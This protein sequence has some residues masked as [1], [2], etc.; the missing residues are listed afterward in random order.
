MKDDIIFSA[1]TGR[2]I[3]EPSGA[4][5]SNVIQFPGQSVTGSKPVASGS[6]A[7]RVTITCLATFISIG[8]AARDE[9]EAVAKPF[10]ENDDI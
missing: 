6:C 8:D 9:I 5:R 10:Q 3:L 7:K 2:R 1:M 4:A